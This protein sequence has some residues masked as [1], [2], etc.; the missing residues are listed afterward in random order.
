VAILLG[1]QERFRF[2]EVG[3][4]SR[5]NSTRFPATGEGTV[6]EPTLI[7]QVGRVL[8]VVVIS[9][10]ALEKNTLF[11]SKFDLCLRQKVAKC[12]IWNV[13][14]CGVEIWTLLKVDQKYLVSFEMW[15]RRRIEKIIGTDGERN[16]EVLHR[17]MR[18]KNIPHTIKR[19]KTNWIGH[20]LRM[21]CLKK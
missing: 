7:S 18:K 9:K 1:C 8:E 2:T 20:I 3:S 11:T 19:R 12:Y 21:N 13:A 5:I 6:N 16:E 10:A 17:H 14:F 4:Y 15:C